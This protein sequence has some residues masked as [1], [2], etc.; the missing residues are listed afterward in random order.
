MGEIWV[1]HFTPEMEENSN[2]WIER[3]ESSPKE[4]KTVLRAVFGIIFIDHPQINSLI[5]RKRKCCPTTNYI[6]EN[7][8]EQRFQELTSAPVDSSQT[9]RYICQPVE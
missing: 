3:G 1:H 8:L 5:L 7:L 6:I 9:K 2:E 4:A